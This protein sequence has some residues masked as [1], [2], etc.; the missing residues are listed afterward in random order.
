MNDI[1][2]RDNYFSPSNLAK[3]GINAIIYSAGGALLFVLQII[4]RFRVIG[5]IV[6]VVICVIGLISLKSKDPA[7][8][9][10]GMVITA[11]GGLTVLSKTGIPFLQALSGTLLS[12]GAFGLIAMGIW[13]GLKFIAGLKKRS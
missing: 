11:A 13:N 9:K 10:P 7:D 3:Y 8:T 5:L 4:S 1:E 6:G 2:P 12:V